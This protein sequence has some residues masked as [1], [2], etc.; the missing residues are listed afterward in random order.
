MAD[1][2]PSSASLGS[3]DIE[4]AYAQHAR[5][6]FAVSARIAGAPL[7]ERITEDVFVRLARV[8]PPFDPARRSLRAYLVGMARHMAIDAARSTPPPAL[9]SNDLA[10]RVGRAL[11]TLSTEA[12]DAINL[13]YFGG[14][15]YRE[16]ALVLGVSLRTMKSRLRDALRRLR[17]ELRKTSAR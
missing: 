16:S 1:T 10:G 2:P 13:A 6:V 3:I 9:L 11:A 12:H 8:P 7:A 14:L 4:R 15:S 17:S 5:F